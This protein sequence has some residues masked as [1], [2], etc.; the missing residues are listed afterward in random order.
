MQPN[1][2]LVERGVI[3]VKGLKGGGLNK[4]HENSQYYISNPSCAAPFTIEIYKDPENF[5]YF[6]ET[7][8]FEHKY[9]RTFGDRLSA[10]IVAKDI[11]RALEDAF[12]NTYEDKG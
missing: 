3:Y 4:M 12:R 9:A 10:I 6:L 5:A 8:I 11:A 1:N 7:T 2:R